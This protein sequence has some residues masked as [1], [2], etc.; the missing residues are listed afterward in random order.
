[1]ILLSEKAGLENNKYNKIRKSK[2]QNIDNYLKNKNYRNKILSLQNSLNDNNK[3]VNVVVSNFPFNPNNNTSRKEFNKDKIDK[4]NYAFYLNKEKN[5][6]KRYF[7]KDIFNNNSYILEKV[8]NSNEEYFPRY[9]NENYNFI[10][11]NEFSDDIK[12]IG[13]RNS[14]KDF[15]LE[16]RKMNQNKDFKQKSHKRLV[17]NIMYHSQP[18]LNISYSSPLLE[19]KKIPMR[20]YY[21]NNFS[22]NLREKINKI[23]S[24]ISIINNKESDKENK[25]KNS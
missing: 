15:I 13:Y 4:N 9:T 17:S 14:S 1:M 8:Y 11:N 22:H 21:K 6:L 12:K 18:R 5:D 7:E 2:G 3:N 16:L 24:D 10:K 25:E 20:T 19:E 23:K